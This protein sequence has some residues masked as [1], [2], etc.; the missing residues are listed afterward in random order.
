[1]SLLRSYLFAPGNSE[2]LL[3]KVMDAGADAV[4]LDLEDAVPAS[5]KARARQLVRAAVEERAG[6]ASP[7]VFVRINAVDT[8]EWRVDLDAVICSALAGIRLPKVESA[9]Q[10]RAADAEIARLERERGLAAG[11]LELACTIETARGVLHAPAIAA[12]CPRLRNLCFGAAD[13]THDVGAEPGKDEAETLFARSQ[14]VVASRAAGIDPPVAAAYI[15]LPDVEGLRRSSEAAR[16]LG[17]FG[18]TCLHPRQIAV[19]HAAFTPPPEAVERARRIAAAH[20]RA[21]KTGTGAVALEDGSFIDLAVA[22]RARK[23][24]A[25]AE[26]VLLS[27]AKKA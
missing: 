15:D 17:F 5:E 14:L 25:L 3:G 9:E 19:V 18:R 12:A 16:R 13:F 4:V 10:A 22:R 1:M 20:D 8:P 26:Q 11:G 23:L 21:V 27:E 7:A 2:R 6:S 24:L